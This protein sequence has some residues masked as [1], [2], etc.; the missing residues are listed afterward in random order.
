MDTGKKILLEW[1]KD[2]HAMEKQAIEIL[3]RQA[4]RTESYPEVQ[5]KMQEHLEQSREQAARVKEC[6]ERLGGDTSAVKEGMAKFMGNASALANSAAGDEIVKNG[7]A[8]YTFEHFEMAAYRALVAAAEEV[9]EDEVRSV[10]AE[11]LEEEKAMARWLEKHLPHLT[12]QYLQ[13]EVTNQQ[14]KR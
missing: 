5:S 2:A 12:Q 8:D 1:L 4:E 7:I 14:A 3:K 13:R 11:I 10:C 9:G 6:I